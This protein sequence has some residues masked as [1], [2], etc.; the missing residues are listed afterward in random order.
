[1]LGSLTAPEIDMVLKSQLIG[2]IGCYAENK[3]LIVPI[4]YVF[5]DGY[6]HGHS[7][8]GEKIISMRKN[9]NV[10][11]EVDTMTNLTNWKSVIIWGLYEEMK[12]EEKTAETMKVLSERIMPLLASETM[13]PAQRLP[14]PHHH[15]AGVKSIAFRIKITE[16]SGRYEND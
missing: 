7:H 10:C 13:R 9:P 2:R 5:K 8:E 6:I 16:K 1:M 14:E 11:F 3:I 15:N 4:T 12:T